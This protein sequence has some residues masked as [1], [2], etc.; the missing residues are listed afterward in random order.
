MSGGSRSLLPETSPT[1]PSGGGKGDGRFRWLSSLVAW[2][3]R[4]ISALVQS[5]SATI[6]AIVILAWVL[7][8]IATPI[9]APYS[10]TEI[11][12]S[13]L[14]APSL[15]HWLGTDHLGRDVLS[16]LFWGTQVILF[17]APTSVALG[18]LTGAPL[19]LIS[20]YV[21]G[22]LDAVIMR[23]VDIL[24]SFPTLLIYI[25]IITSIGSSAVIVV[26]AISL[27]SVPPITRIVRSLTLDERTKDYVNAARL[28]G[29]RRRYI[30]LREI[31]P[32]VSGPII[33]DS[34]IRV[35]YAIMAI[36][37]LGFLGL[38]IPPPTP[39]WGGMINE[40]R[41]WIFSMPW[42]VVAPAAALSSV[43]IGLNLLADG[44]REIGQQ[45]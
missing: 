11:Q 23:G 1:S 14:Q 38:G 42:M 12:G 2:L 40:G 20:G 34:C 30:L 10:P 45:R 31:L 15:E 19:G 41:K 21:G 4:A 24:L 43:V 16:R 26:I 39:D 27:G 28:R 6:G 8:A 35:G 17:L 22:R 18:I 44:I 9:V 32:N 37:S 25:L 36:G 3:R 33:V 5:R 13:R 29:E 7:I